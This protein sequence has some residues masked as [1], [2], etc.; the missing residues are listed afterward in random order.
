LPPGLTPR[1][2]EVLKLLALGLKYSEIAESG[3]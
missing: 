1:E 3:W 2:V